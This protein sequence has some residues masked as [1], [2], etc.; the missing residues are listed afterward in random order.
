MRVI[1]R[2][3]LDV[4]GQIHLYRWRRAQKSNANRTDEL[5]LRWTWLN[6]GQREHTNGRTN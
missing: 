1:A 2:W 3:D 6:A 4:A 5:E